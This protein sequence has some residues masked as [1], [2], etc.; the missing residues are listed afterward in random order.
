MVVHSNLMGF[1]RTAGGLTRFLYL[2]VVPQ[3]VCPRPCRVCGGELLLRH[4]ISLPRFFLPSLPPFPRQRTRRRTGT[5][6]QQFPGL[7]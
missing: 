7:D 4:R 2:F 5:K 6:S 3:S 1:A